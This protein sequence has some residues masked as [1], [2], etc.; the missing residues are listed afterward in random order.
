MLI[1]HLVKANVEN[2]GKNDFLVI[3]IGL[4]QWKNKDEDK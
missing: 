2:K 4:L 3:S 1:H